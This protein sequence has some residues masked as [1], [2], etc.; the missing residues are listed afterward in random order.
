MHSYYDFEK[1]EFK[2]E[3]G[4]ISQRSYP[5]KAA[6]FLVENKIK[7]NFFNDFNS[8]AYLL[9]RT[10]PDIKVFIDGR[11]DPYGDE[12]IVTYRNITLVRPKWQE[13]L[14][15]YDVHT[16]IIGANSTLSLAMNADPAWTRVYQDDVAEIFVNQ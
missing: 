2:S 15:A 16:A 4:G 12:L 1:Y 5:D 11:A 3:F 13:S 6:D 7:G 9:G 8:G 14:Q 10:F